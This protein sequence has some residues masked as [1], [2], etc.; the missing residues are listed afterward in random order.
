MT[1]ELSRRIQLP[2]HM[3]ES[4]CY[5]Y[6]VVKALCC[7]FIW[8]DFIA[9]SKQLFKNDGHKYMYGKHVF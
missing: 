5:N 3:G 9:Q 6:L 8:L 7:P 2:L 4:S 1:T